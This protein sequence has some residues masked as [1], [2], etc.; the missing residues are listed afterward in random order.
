[1]IPNIFRI[2]SA[3]FP[4]KWIY[5]EKHLISSIFQLLNF[6]KR[7][8]KNVLWTLVR[9]TCNRNA[10]ALWCPNNLRQQLDRKERSFRAVNK[11]INNL[12]DGVRQTRPRG[13]THSKYQEWRNFLYSAQFLSALLFRFPGICDVY[14]IQSLF[15]A[16][17][18]IRLRA[19]WTSCL[20]ILH[21]RWSRK[22]TI[23]ESDNLLYIK[24]KQQ[25][26]WLN[27][28]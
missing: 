13:M 16:S 19:G 25:H 20:M 27:Q 14:T 21:S 5:S 15:R 8:Q 23:F 4:W 26:S 7:Y 10:R 12:C 28:Y 22:P 3:D 1:M 9:R 17:L 24:L 6:L 2:S 18:T 11:F